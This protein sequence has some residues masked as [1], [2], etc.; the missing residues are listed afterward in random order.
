MVLKFKQQRAILRHY[1]EK[2]SLLIW[3]C[4]RYCSTFFETTNVEID[5]SE[6]LRAE[7]SVCVIRM[8]SVGQGSSFFFPFLSQEQLDVVCILPCSY[9]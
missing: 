5:N 9:D 1:D 6:S 7:K 8:L 3:L 2:R 4:G